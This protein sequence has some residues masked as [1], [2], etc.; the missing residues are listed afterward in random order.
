M[1]SLSL[2]LCVCVCVCVRVCSEL[3][4]EKLI[5][6]LRTL[7]RSEYLRCS[8]LRGKNPI[9]RSELNSKSSE[10]IVKK[11]WIHVRDF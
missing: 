8:D 3:R 11:D 10:K 7:E 2:S 6:E 1:G 4:G 9:V 5:L